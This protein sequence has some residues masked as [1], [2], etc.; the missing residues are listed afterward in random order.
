MP[1]V[2]RHVYE[3]LRDS[4]AY[5]TDWIDSLCWKIFAVFMLVLAFL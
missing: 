1:P 3:M 2:L 5:D 4:G